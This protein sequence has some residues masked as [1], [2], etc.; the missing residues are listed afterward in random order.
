MVLTIEVT[1]SCHETPNSAWGGNA[2][3]GARAPG[4]APLLHACKLWAHIHAHVCYTARS[5]IGSFHSS[6]YR[7]TFK[8]GLRVPPICLSS[9]APR[10]LARLPGPGEKEAER[11][12]S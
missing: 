11:A 12:R 7:L 5:L 4:P 2:E 10:S 6:P 1:R 8:G 9:I 3:D